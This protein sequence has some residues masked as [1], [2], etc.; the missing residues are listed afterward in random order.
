METARLPELQPQIKQQQPLNRYLCNVIVL[1]H[2]RQEVKQATQSGH[3]SSAA[4][5]FANELQYSSKTIAR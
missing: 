3:V 4:M 1:H 2:M 5:L